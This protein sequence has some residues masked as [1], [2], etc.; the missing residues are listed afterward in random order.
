MRRLKSIFTTLFMFS[1]VMFN[2]VL[3]SSENSLTDREISNAVDN[4]LIINA[5]TPSYMI[6]VQTTDGIVTLEGSTDNILAKDRAVKIARTVKGVRG[7][8]DRID[9][10]APHRSDAILENDISTALLNDPATDSYELTVEAND[11]HIDLDGV[12]DSWQE[13]QLSA[14]V[15]KGVTGVESLDNNITISYEDERLDYEIR[16]DIEQALNND[17][18]VDGAL[19]DVTVTNGNVLLAGTVGS[20]NEK[21]L[22][23]SEAWVTGV[24]TVNDENLEVKEW[25]REDNLRKDKYV[26]KDDTEVKDAIKDAFLYDPRVLSFNPNVNVNDGVVTLTGTVDNLKAKLAAEQ[27]ARNV[28]GVFRVKNFIKV[29]PLFIPEDADLE[30]TV[31][32]SLIKNPGVQ[33]SEIDVTAQN[34][35]VYL[36]GTVDSYFEKSKAENIASTSKGVIDIENNLKVQDENDYYLYNYYGWNTYHPPYHVDVAYGFKPDYAIKDDIVDQLWWS[37]YVNEDEIIV[38]VDNGTATLKGTVDTRR[39]KRFAE[40]NALEG[41]ASEV[42]NNLLVDYSP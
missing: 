7:V 34:G 13:K 21:S 15:A 41:G 11:G 29:R 2:G 10:K 23:F 4:E 24:K 17:I 38:T 18:R 1:I 28:V 40:I 26:D 6:D 25:A 30:A 12:V 19:I 31:N 3:F 20:A 27:N 35:V 5:T 32:S 16:E 36:N 8:I 14:Y 39:E 37:P 22:A 9:V 42:D 33:K